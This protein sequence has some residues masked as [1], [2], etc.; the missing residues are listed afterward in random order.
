MDLKL[1]KESYAQLKDVLYE[2]ASIWCCIAQAI[3][4]I[5]V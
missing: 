1:A 3:P 5:L 4:T 2:G